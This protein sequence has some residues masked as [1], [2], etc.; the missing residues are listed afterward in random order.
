MTSFQT[1]PSIASMFDRLLAD[2]MQTPASCLTQN[3]V[4]PYD[5]SPALAVDTE[6]AWKDV[7]F[8]AGNYGLTLSQKDI[9]QEWQEITQRRA[10][11]TFVPCALGHYPQQISDW[12][13]SVEPL[14]KRGNLAAERQITLSQEAKIRKRAQAEPLFAV[15]LARLAGAMDLALEILAAIKPTKDNAWVI[16]N[17]K[18]AIHWQAG[19]TNAAEAIWA[20]LPVNTVVLFNRGMAAAFHGDQAQAT[21]HL[22]SAAAGL[23]ETSGWYHLAQMHLAEFAA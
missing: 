20:K 22:E 17:E 4:E 18:A 15:S 8:V 3:L 7:R 19:E 23:P 9:P 1:Q 5:A 21:K 6:A 10:S 12:N 16:E 2:A 11:A 14:K 13:A